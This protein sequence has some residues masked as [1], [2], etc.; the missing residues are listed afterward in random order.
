MKKFYSFLIMMMLCTVQAIAIDI[1]TSYSGPV[2]DMSQLAVGDKLLLFCN[3][4]TDP[5]DKEYG[6]RNA[7]MREVDDNF[8]KISRDLRVGTKE[9]S[10][11]VWT[12]LSYEQLDEVSYQLSLQSPRGNYLPTF[13]DDLDTYGQWSRWMGRTVSQ[14]EG[15][16][17]LL[18]I[19]ISEVADSLFYIFDENGVYFNGQE[20]PKGATTGSANFV[21]WNS[22]GANSLYMIYKAETEAHDTYAI[23]ML[24]EDENGEREEDGEIT[25]Q[26]LMGDTIQAPAWENHSLV[27]AYDF[28][29]DEYIEFPYIVD[30]SEPY[31]IL[32]YET[33]PYVTIDCVDAD[34]EELIFSTAS[35]IQKGQKLPLPT[36]QQVG[37]GYTLITEG[38]D[39]FTI[40]EDVSIRLEYRRDGRGLPFEPTTVENGQFA[41]GTKWYLMKIRGT[42]DLSYN[43]ND[44]GIKCTALTEYTDSALFA[45]SG[46]MQDGF[47]IYNKVT[48]PDQILW[49]SDGNDGTAVFFAPEADTQAPN[50]FDISFNNDG[51]SLKLHSTANAY[52]NDFA[53]AGV[54]KFWANNAGATDAGSKITFREYTDAL[55]DALK[56][57]EYISYLQAENCVGGWTA[58]QL[59]DLKAAYANKDLAACQAAAEAL[60]EADTIAFDSNKAYIFVSAYKNFITSQP[61][62][63]AYA[64]AV[65]NGDS[66]VWKVADESN[67]AFH[68]G[69]RTASDSTYYIVALEP[70]LPIG[71]FR[72]NGHAMCAPWGLQGNEDGSFDEGVPAPFEIQKNANAPAAYSFV[73]NYGASII[74]LAGAPVSNGD[75]TSGYITTY[76]TLT[77]AYNNYWRLKPVGEWD[78]ISETVVA[79]PGQQKQVIYDLSGRRVQKAVKG[80]YII[81]GKKVY[82]K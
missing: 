63:P 5:N 25:V 77:A 62:A 40:T 49:A 47:K 61:G 14:D 17:G 21:G 37:L 79:E 67:K 30:G 53:N 78:A 69:F 76:N 7:F 72:F 4:P 18:T 80:L 31:L 46:N 65:E 26:G 54:L 59:A 8:V 66:L 36:D 15:T 64:M 57:G 10:D 60:A 39:N 71:G 58:E 9:S 55:A 28:D 35:Y 45:F 52:V 41:P 68:F 23:T 82:V 70:G 27:R 34:T 1:V 11:Y 44:L 50:T 24:L 75:A 48:G 33:W 38:Y 13:I 29:K 22:P 43:E 73:H 3:G 81:N 32:T 12:V 20:I 42:K 51:F 19:T 56:F 16:P 2:K 6:T 74:T